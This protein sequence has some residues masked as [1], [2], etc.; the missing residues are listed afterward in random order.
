[1]SALYE[2][3]VPRPSVPEVEVLAK[4][5]RRRFPAERGVPPPLSDSPSRG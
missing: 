5:S 1:M 4:A 3:T 2:V